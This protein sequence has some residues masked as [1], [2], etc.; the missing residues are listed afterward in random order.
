MDM[1]V[2]DMI[3]KA[4]VEFRHK[5][6]YTKSSSHTE[7]KTEMKNRPVKDMIVKAFVA[8]G[9][10]TSHTKSLPIRNSKLK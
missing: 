3:V 9:H 7:F 5:T 4:F 8:F 6:S 10:E 2:K 1:T